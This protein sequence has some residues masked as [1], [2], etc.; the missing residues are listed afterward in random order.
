LVGVTYTTG[1]NVQSVNYRD[2]AADEGSSDP[3]RLFKQSTFATTT[4]T[5]TGEF[6]S[7][8]GKSKTLYGLGAKPSDPT[9]EYAY[10]DG[11][12]VLLPLCLLTN[13]VNSDNFHLNFSMA[14]DAAKQKYDTKT[15]GS[16]DIH[17]FNSREA[18]FVMD[19]FL[20]AMLKTM[21]GSRKIYRQG[22]FD[23][24][25]E[26]IAKAHSFPIGLE[27][28]GPN[29][30][31]FV[32]QK[33]RISVLH[34]DNQWGIS[35]VGKFPFEAQAYDP[36]RQRIVIGG[37]TNIQ[38]MEG[39]TLRFMKKTYVRELG[40]AGRLFLRI[41][42]NTGDLYAMRKGNP[43]MVRL[44][45]A[46]DGSVRVV[47]V[48][49]LPGAPT[50]DSFD[51]SRNGIYAAQSGHVMQFRADGTSVRN[52]PFAGMPCGDNLKFSKNFN[53]WTADEYPLPGWR[54]LAEPQQ[55]LR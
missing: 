42:P 44:K 15:L 2:P 31:L 11:Y 7:F 23:T 9:K 1:S 26:E 25:A 22:F 35:K 33:D 53:N 5:A 45:M 8:D 38:V 4:R 47:D 41:D 24:T 17:G 50:P 19:P 39:E 51:F 55:P 20:P 29:M 10:I 16:V 14:Y 30:D 54:D 12:R 46:G 13:V 36:I 32:L 37:D 6:A 21:D 43:N 40:G 3:F 52:S 18:D 34:R 28:G 49:N 48:F 27:Y